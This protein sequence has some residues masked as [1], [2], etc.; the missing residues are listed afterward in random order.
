MKRWFKM[1]EE[2]KAER[3]VELREKWP[4]MR[5][6][7]PRQEGLPHYNSWKKMDLE[8]FLH[9]I[10]ASILHSW[11]DYE[12]EYEKQRFQEYREDIIKFIDSGYSEKYP[13]CAEIISKMVDTPKMNFEETQRFVY[14]ILKSFPP[15]RWPIR[16]GRSEEFFTLEKHEYYTLENGDEQE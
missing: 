10:D 12:K 16:R 7:H 5:N 15:N 4:S 11:I 3:L 6:N 14:F 13:Y 9:S 2:E 1:T 8:K